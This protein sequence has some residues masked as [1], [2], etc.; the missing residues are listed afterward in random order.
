MYDCIIALISVT[1]SS[2]SRTGAN[3]DSSVCTSGFRSPLDSGAV[4]A[5][6]S[7]SPVEDLNVM[8]G[9]HAV[10]A[11]GE[12]AIK[13][14]LSPGK[15]ADLSGTILQIIRVG[16]VCVSGPYHCCTKRF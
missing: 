16:N 8:K 1:F 7:N 5:L 9:I 3:P 6:G 14:T 13:A 15:L 2:S 4:L 11:S 10:Y 12:E